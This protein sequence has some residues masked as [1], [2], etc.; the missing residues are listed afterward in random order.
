MMVALEALKTS[1]AYLN[2]DVEE[3]EKTQPIQLSEVDSNLGESIEDLEQIINNSLKINE[4]V[5]SLQDKCRDAQ[6]AIQENQE[7]LKLYCQQFA[8][9]PEMNP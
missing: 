4:L 6:V 9:A 8:F 7:P 5:V 2:K 1:I 3:L